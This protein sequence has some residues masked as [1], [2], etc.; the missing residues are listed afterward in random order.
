MKP[1][2]GVSG[3]V[4]TKVSNNLLNFDMNIVPKELT[5]ALKVAGA[6]PIVFPLSTA[7]EAKE[8]GLIDDVLEPEKLQ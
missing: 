5:D 8:Y 2:V 6:L 7:E 3:Y 4:M 1:V